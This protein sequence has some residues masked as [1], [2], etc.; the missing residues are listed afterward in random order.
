MKKLSIR[1]KTTVW[2][3]TIAGTVFCV[4]AAFVVDIPIFG[5]M[6]SAQ[7]RRALAVHTWLPVALAG[8]LL[9]LLLSKIRALALAHDEMAK[10]AMTDALTGMLNRGAFTMMVEAYL[11]HASEARSGEHG[12]LLVVDVDHFKSVNDRFGHGA[13]DEALRRISQVMQSAIR[14]TDLVGRIGGEEFAVFLPAANAP[15]AV[16]VAERIREHV[17]T[18]E[19]PDAGQYLLSV[20]IG[21]VNFSRARKFDILFKAADRCLYL[22][23]E[24]G[25]NRVDMTDYVGI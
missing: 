4:L 12:S 7:L 6:T 5:D 21:G 1:S 17:S 18:I 22:A 13:G 11:E 23:K 25:R 10:L 2:L 20:S 14:S 3:G 15:Q 19:F 9:F 8:P 24:R 16:Q